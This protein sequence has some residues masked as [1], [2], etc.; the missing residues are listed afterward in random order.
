MVFDHLL[1]RLLEREGVSPRWAIDAQVATWR[2]LWGTKD[3][4]PVTEHLNDNE[5]GEAVRYVL[6]Y[7][8]ARVTTLRG[9][10]ASLDY[11]LQDDTMIA[12]QN[13]ARHL[14][15]DAEFGLDAVLLSK[16]AGSDTMASGFL[17]ALSEI[18]EPISAGEIMDYVLA[19][20]GMPRSSAEWRV[21]G[22]RRVGRGKSSGFRFTTFVIGTPFDE[23]SVQR[24]HEVLERVAVAAYF[25]H[26]D[27][28]DIRARFEGNGKAVAY[29]DEDTESGVVM[30]DDD[31]M[32]WIVRPSVARLDHPSR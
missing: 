20:Y 10:V 4:P 19:P 8:G 25:A 18:A 26:H 15:T 13:T 27:T 9:L 12:L 11:A 1:S 30:I 29:W 31:T 23:L 2:F 3:L 28:T 32:S 6:S 16:A 21:E 7:A 14:L 24:A 17:G 22:I 5:N